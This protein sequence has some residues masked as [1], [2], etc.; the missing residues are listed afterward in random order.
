MH[1]LYTVYQYNI[2]I[3]HIHQIVI[4]HKLSHISQG[5][6]PWG[7]YL[8]YPNKLRLLGHEAFRFLRIEYQRI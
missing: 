1:H 3:L 6:I 5:S 8:I 7:G 4:S 2:C